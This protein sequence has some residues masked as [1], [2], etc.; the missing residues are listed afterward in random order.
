MKSANFLIKP[1]SGLCNMRCWY[2]FYSDEM[3]N[4]EIPSYGI[5]QPET[6]RALI[7][8]AFDEVEEQCTFAFQ[9]GEPT[10]AG[11]GF[12]RAFTEMLREE[13]RRGTAVSLAIQTNGYSLD[14]EWA[15][16]FA[17]EG[18]LV[19]LSFDGDPE[20]HDLY[21]R[22][23][24]GNGTSRRVLRAAALLRSHRVPFNLLT[25]VTAQAARHPDRIYGY[26]K[27]QGFG[28]QQYIPCLDPIGEPRGGQKYSLTPALYGQFLK[29]LFDLWYTDLST[30]TQPYIRYFENLVG[31][32]LGQ[33]PEAC[34]ML[35]HCTRQLVVEAD[36]GVYPCDFY[37]LD[38][39][40]IGS[41]RT[42]SLPQI[43][44]ARA[45]LGFIEE[46]LMRDPA[47][48]A[49]RWYPLCRGGCRRDRDENGVLGLNY[50]CP[51]YREFFAHAVP[52]LERI[53]QLLGARR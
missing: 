6:A 20:L 49:C 46:S 36:G 33:I 3:E 51:A 28:F 42:D 12:F 1:A 47:C 32:L 18:F 37:V 40:R 43:E 35:G 52:R 8:R 7:R 19:G 14:E 27:R 11:L 31:M 21:R 10:L 39:C 13:N 9:G 53:A 29:R 23:P 4:R 25:V 24:D 45:R 44:E 50:F 30:G 5:M 41:V 17:Q 34:G 15:A 38:R 22:G 26:Y 2:C 48:G 16:F